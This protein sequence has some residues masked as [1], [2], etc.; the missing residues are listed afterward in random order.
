MNVTV[1]RE[2]VLIKQ[3]VNEAKTKGGIVFTHT[4]EEKT[5]QGIVIG[6]GTGRKTDDGN[7]IP[8]DLEVGNKVLYDVKAGTK[9]TLEGEDYIMLKEQD[10]Y[11]VVEE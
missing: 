4:G 9:V 7:Y 10:I 2:R 8:I 6:V 3:I 11:A 5:N 1:M